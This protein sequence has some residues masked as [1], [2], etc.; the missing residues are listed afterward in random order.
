[1]KLQ[2][3]TDEQ[4]QAILKCIQLHLPAVTIYAFGSRVNGKPRKYSDLD[5]ALDMKRSI[6]LFEISKIKEAISETDLPISVDLIDYRSVSSEFKKIID[7]G[8]IVLV[9]D[10]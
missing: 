4:L 2:G 1:M 10:K 8:K 7:H 9:K 6:N 5:L 3:I